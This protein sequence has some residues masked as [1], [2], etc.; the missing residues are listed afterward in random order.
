[1]TLDPAGTPPNG[2]LIY[3]YRPTLLG[4]PSTFALTEGGMDWSVGGRTGRVRYRDVRRVRLSFKP[5][6]IQAYRFLTEIWAEGAP[7]LEIMSSSWKSMV[8]QERRDESYAAF[9]AELHTRVATA[10]SPVPVG[11]ERGANPFLYWPGLVLYS[12]VT[13]G[14]AA[15]FA[16]AL[17]LE[18]YGAA[19]FIGG[20][21]ALLLW[22]GGN[23]FHRNRPGSYRPDA[24]PRALMPRA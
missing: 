1:M 9:V 19:A 7:K 14:L 15:T 17:Q 13:L 22:Q 4:A 23:F 24:L 2:D 18:T 8:E 20:F 11:Y 10:G 6:S 21:G 3:S 16:R 12:V 5:G